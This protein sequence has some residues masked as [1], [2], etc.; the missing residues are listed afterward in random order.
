MTKIASLTLV[1]WFIHSSWRQHSKHLHCSK[2]K[3]VPVCILWFLL[4]VVPV[5]VRLWWLFSPKLCMKNEAYSSHIAIPAYFNLSFDLQYASSWQQGNTSCTWANC[6]VTA[7]AKSTLQI[8]MD[9]VASPP[10]NICIFFF[11]KWMTVCLF[12]SFFRLCLFD[13]TVYNMWYPHII[14]CVAE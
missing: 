1:V 14:H 2:V 3:S 12:L 9:Y 4:A 6:W 10:T 13:F 8:F 5:S 7:E 11:A